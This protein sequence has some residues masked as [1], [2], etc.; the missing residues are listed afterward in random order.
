MGT[1]SAFVDP[2]GVV[3]DFERPAHLLAQGHQLAVTRPQ[4]ELARAAPASA[5]P[6][7]LGVSPLVAP[8]G[9]AWSALPTQTP[10]SPR[11]GGFF[12]AVTQTWRQGS[13]AQRS[14]SWPERVWGVT[15]NGILIP[16]G[17]RKQ[18]T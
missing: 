10:V 16:F 12:F 9:P 2:R 15:G 6:L 17:S 13:W 1:R 3:T 4:Q 18:V 14:L 11:H 8:V 5:C 7:S